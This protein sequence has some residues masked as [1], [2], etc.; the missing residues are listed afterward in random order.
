[1]KILITGGR[2][3]MAA[4]LAARQIGFGNQVVVT[5]S[6]QESADGVRAMYAARNLAVDVV[7]FPL[8]P[9]IPPS[10]DLEAVLDAGVDALVLNAAPPIKRFKLAHLYT[11]DEVH[12]QISLNVEGNVR[13]V[14][15]VLPGM[16][17]KSFGRLVFVSSAM[18][19]TGTTKHGL[20]C[21][22]KGAM[23][24]FFFNL[25]VDYGKKNILANVLRPGIV[26]TE[27]TRRFWKRPAYVEKARRLIPQ[28]VLGEPAQIAEAFDP[29]LSPTS[30]MTGSVVTVSGGLPL[31]N[32]GGTD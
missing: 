7:V 5:A 12:S 17:A 4:A 30:Y 19:A 11:P 6:S 24:A 18:V 25:A 31:M 8:D 10:F 26:R 29:L 27:R 13:L 3:E 9:T 32:L 21:L 1:M 22:S 20:Y 14:Q 2:S 28:G 15:R 16:I 23:E